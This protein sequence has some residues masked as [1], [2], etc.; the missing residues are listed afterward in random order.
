MKKRDA[1]SSKRRNNLEGL[2][3]EVRRK[4]NKV[5]VL[6]LSATPVVNNLLE[7]R[8]LLE[9]ITGKVYDDVVTNPTVPNA[10]TLYEKLSTVSVREIPEYNIKKRTKH[11]QVQLERPKELSIKALRRNPLAIEKFLTVARISNIL[12]CIKDRTIIYTEYIT[13]II[14]LLSRAIGEA[15][16]SYA[17]YTGE[18]KTGLSRFLN[19]KGTGSY[20]LSSSICGR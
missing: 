15:G 13:E 10:V 17:L 20:C 2:M 11:I 14:E 16:F 12:K 18:D 1:E 19:K 8:S 7:G 4:N 9:L 5:K 3:T 6:G